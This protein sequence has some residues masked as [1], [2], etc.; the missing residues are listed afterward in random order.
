MHMNPLKIIRRRVVAITIFSTL[1]PAAHSSGL[2]LL[3]KAVSG[4]AS[5]AHANASVEQVPTSGTIEVAFSPNEG[6]LELVLKVINSARS[7]VRVMAYSFTSAPVSKALIAAQKR[8]VAVKLVVDHKSNMGEDR[9]GK[10]R[11]ALAAL[12]NAGVDVRTIDAYAIAHDKVIIV[13]A[14][15]VQTGSFN[16]SASAVS[17]NSENV[18]VNWGN[19]ALAQAY[20]RHFE[21]NYRQSRKLNLG[22]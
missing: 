8:G 11:S 14:K 21:R 9:S 22:Y 10:A 6:A 17:R 4:L 3:A 1:L 20:M 13:D 12:A 15:T 16:Y 19:Q 5:A 7:E 2:D 18:L